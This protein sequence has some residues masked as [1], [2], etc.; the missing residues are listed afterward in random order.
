[1]A[2]ELAIECVAADPQLAVPGF[3]DA[4]RATELLSGGDWLEHN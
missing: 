1:M 3:A 4:V 2:R